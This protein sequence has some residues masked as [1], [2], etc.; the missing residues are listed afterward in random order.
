MVPTPLLPP[1]PSRPNPATAWLKRRQQQAALAAA[2][3]PAS[4]DAPIFSRETL[5]LAMLLSCLPE[6]LDRWLLEQ[7]R[8]IVARY[9]SRRRWRWPFSWRASPPEP[10]DRLSHLRAQ[11][12]AELA[13]GLML[14]AVPRKPMSRPMRNQ[15]LVERAAVIGRLAG[16]LARAP[17]AAP[18]EQELARL[19]A[20]LYR[21]G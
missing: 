3:R 4:P 6:Y 13:S 14:I 19:L 18:L 15:T 20:R 8:Q 12:Q 5:D 2:A 21:Q 17:G 1:L 16:E 10:R 7:A 9:Q 11:L